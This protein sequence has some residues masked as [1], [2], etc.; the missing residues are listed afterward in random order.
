TRSKIA[1]KPRS[2]QTH[3][4]RMTAK[5]CFPPIQSERRDVTL[6][7]HCVQDCWCGLRLNLSKL[8]RL[9][10]YAVTFSTGSCTVTIGHDFIEFVVSKR[11][12]T[13]HKVRREISHRISFR[14]TTEQPFCI[15]VTH[16]Q[17]PKPIHGDTRCS[18]FPHSMTMP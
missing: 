15:G 3:K 12:T 11:E 14:I 16:T 8:L 4:H 5:R 7:Y 1:A 2:A 9:D 13:A 6:K 10:V 17:P 18:L